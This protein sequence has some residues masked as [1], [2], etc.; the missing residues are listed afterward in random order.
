MKVNNALILT[1]RVKMDTKEKVVHCKKDFYDVY[2]GR[3]SKWGNPFEISLDQ[4]REQVL[5]KYEVWLRGNE[6]LLADL[7]ELRGKT[8]G[9]W[10]F[11]KPCHG[12]VLI[13]LL[14][15]LCD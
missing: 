1:L 15:E 4:N 8:L 2:I 6:K 10:C 7:E 12:N 3:P 11:P 14:H 9:C 13:K 5:E